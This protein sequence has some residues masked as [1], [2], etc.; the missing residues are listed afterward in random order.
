MSSR[1]ALE[2]EAMGVGWKRRGRRAGRGGKRSGDDSERWELVETQ[3]H[4][5][6]GGDGGWE[7][8]SSG[9]SGERVMRSVLKGRRRT[10]ERNGKNIGWSE[11]EEKRGVGRRC[12]QKRGVVE[13]RRK[14]NIFCF[15]FRQKKRFD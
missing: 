6:G 2:L 10:K 13:G 12:G 11:R 8:G 3:R 7:C 1:A 4:G 14:R 15:F 5:C 9:K